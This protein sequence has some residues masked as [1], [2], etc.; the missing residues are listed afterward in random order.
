MSTRSIIRVEGMKGICVYKHWGGYPENTLP[1]LKEF[2]KSFTEERTFDDPEYKFAQ[3]LRSSAF[4][5]EKFNLGKDRATGWG[6]I[7][8]NG[9]IDIPCDIAYAYTLKKDGTVKVYSPYYN[10]KT[11]K[12]ILKEV[13]TKI[14]K[15]ILDN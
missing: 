11:G 7:I 8:L 1:W 5:C 15:E 3:L 9:N 2:N 13:K 6:V 14:V 4:D 10:K 12:M